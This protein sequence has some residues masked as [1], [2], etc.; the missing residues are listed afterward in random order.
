MTGANPTLGKLGL[1]SFLCFTFALDDCPWVLQTN[2]KV[3]DTPPLH[4]Q[5]SQ[6]QFTLGDSW[7]SLSVEVRNLKGTNVSGW[8]RQQVP[9]HCIKCCA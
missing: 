4:T 6:V 8:V 7:V 2:A 1:P 5:D 3:K 9:L